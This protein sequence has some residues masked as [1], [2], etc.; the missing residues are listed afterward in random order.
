[1]GGFSRKRLSDQLEFEGFTS[2]Q[3]AYALD[4]VGY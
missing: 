3:I 4:A 1:M 2:S